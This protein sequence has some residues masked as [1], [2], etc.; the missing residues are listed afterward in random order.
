MQT[1]TLPEEQARL[2]I[3]PFLSSRNVAQSQEEAL[4]SVQELTK[5]HRPCRET[6]HKD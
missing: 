6:E 2:V 1:R 3:E 5:G 4:P